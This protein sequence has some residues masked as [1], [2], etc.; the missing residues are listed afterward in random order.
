MKL[1]KV[2]ENFVLSTFFFVFIFFDTH[3]INEN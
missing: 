1:S 3:K 2:N